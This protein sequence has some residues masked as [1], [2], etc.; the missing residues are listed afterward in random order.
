[1]VRGLYGDDVSAEVW[2][3][4]QTQSLDS[5]GS[6]GLASRE[7]ELSEL[8]IRFQHDH[9]RAKHNTS[10]LLLVVIDLDCCIMRHSIDDHLGLVSLQVGTGTS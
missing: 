9:V 3:E 2:P 10:F 8:L 4:Q 5:V 6:L 7:T 1:M